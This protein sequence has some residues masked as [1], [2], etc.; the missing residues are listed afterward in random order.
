MYLQTYFLISDANISQILKV[1]CARPDIIKDLIRRDPER[2]RKLAK[3]FGF[4]DSLPENLTPE[5]LDLSPVC[6]KP[7]E[8]KPKGFFGLP[9]IFASKF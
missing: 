9:D 2:V 1:V 6:G 7:G 4:G 8:P 5:N 3:Q